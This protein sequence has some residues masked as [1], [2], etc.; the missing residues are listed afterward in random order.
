MYTDQFL[1]VSTDQTL[2]SGQTVVVSTDTVDLRHIRDMGEGKTIYAVANITEEPTTPLT[3][4]TA[5][6]SGDVVAKTA[7][8]LAN[9][10]AIR[11]ATLSAACGLDTTTTYYVVAAAADTF[12][13]SLT[14]GGVAV[15]I[16]A[17][18]TATLVAVPGLM[19]LQ[20]IT[21][22]N[23]ALTAD[24]QVLGQSDA[25]GGFVLKD[26]A[27][28]RQGYTF[29]IKLNPL[30]SGNTEASASQGNTGARY[31]GLRYVAGSGMHTGHKVTGLFVTDV[32]D[33]R[34]AYTS[35]FTVV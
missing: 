26:S 30:V 34:K 4:F 18:A 13:V 29:A 10:T 12:Q 15:V 8:G 28:Q 14:I 2:T 31:M 32:Q 23:T 22:S 35:G 33:G 3:G 17:D 6:N 11:F 21:A 16:T 24:V 9:G 27:G 1:T 19:Y 20:A 5:T 25:V 7:H